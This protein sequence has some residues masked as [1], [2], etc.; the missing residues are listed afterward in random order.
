MKV[1]VIN[2]GCKVNQSECDSIAAQFAAEGYTV[3]QQFSLADVYIINT[4][5]VTAE[6]EKKSRQCIARVRK[7]N[8]DARIYVI[9]CASQKNAAQFVGKNLTYIGGNA[10]KLA[11]CRLPQGVNQAPL[12]TSFES[13]PMPT[14]KHARPIVKIQD[15]CNNFCSYCIVPYLR[16]RSRSRAIDD[17]VEECRQ[18]ATQCAEIVLTGINVSAYGADI[19]V[20]L[21]QLVDALCGIEGVRFRFGS[22]EAGV[23]DEDFLSAM[24]RAGNFCDHFH[25]SLQSG[26]DEVLATMNRHY[27]TAQYAQK[28][29]L[30]RHYFP[31]AAITTDI[32]VGFATETDQD[33]NQTMAFAQKMEFADIHIFPYSRR[34]GTKAYALPTPDSS[35]VAARVQQLTNLKTQLHTRYIQS[36]VGQ[37]LQMAVETSDGLFACGHSANYIKLYID[38]KAMCR[39]DQLYTVRCLRPYRDGLLVQRV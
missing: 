26:S 16:G 31:F 18:K 10:D 38:D 29:Q 3:D 21:R 36:F 34:Q 9:G 37:T 13:M 22:L 35:V 28:V 23:I 17:I 25:L 4:C 33:F 12:P 27:N 7:Y 15:G 20:S 14:G 11:V 39:P 8:P 32:I 5:A 6:A 30:I 2:L 24:Q 1:S 19:G